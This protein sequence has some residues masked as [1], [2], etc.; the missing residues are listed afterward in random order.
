MATFD[1][2]CWIFQHN[3]GLT[4]EVGLACLAHLSRRR[5]RFIQLSEIAAH[6]EVPEAYGQKVLAA[7]VHAGLVES[8]RGKGYCLDRDARDINLRQVLDALSARNHPRLEMEG[9]EF[10]G[11]ERRLADALAAR[12]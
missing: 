6:A 11:I 3:S 10:A 12:L 8:S 1:P 2:G 4:A 5:G 7:L 9:R